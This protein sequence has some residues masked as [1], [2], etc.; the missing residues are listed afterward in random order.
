MKNPFELICFQ[1]YAGWQGLPVDL[2]DHESHGQSFGTD[3][4]PDGAT[5]G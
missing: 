5:T 1:T 2:S 4:L 3:F